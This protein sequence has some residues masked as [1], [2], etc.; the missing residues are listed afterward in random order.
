MMNSN[1][2]DIQSNGSRTNIDF[3]ISIDQYYVPQYAFSTGVSIANMGGVLNYQNVKTLSTSEGT[4]ISL[5]AN[6]NVNYNLQYIHVPIAVKMRTPQIGYVSYFADLGFDAM[7]NVQANADINSLNIT[8]EGLVNEIKPIYLAYHL[9]AGLQYRIAGTTSLM[10][11][12]TYMNGF[13]DVT[14]DGPAN[15]S[16]N[17]LEIRLGILF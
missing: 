16:M 9:S 5:P 4:T 17:C 10:A 2:S 15:I 6:T 14:N 8:N 13:T 3:G 1:A 11:G 7:V 12:L